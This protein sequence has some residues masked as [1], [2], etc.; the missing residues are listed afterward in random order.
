MTA[1]SA[2][3]GGART[4]TIV[5][6]ASSD[7]EVHARHDGPVN[8]IVQSLG[9]AATQRDVGDGTLPCLSSGSEL[10]LDSSES[11]DN[12]FSGPQDPPMTSTIVPHPLKPKTL[13]AM[14]LTVL[15]TRSCG[16]RRYRHSGYHDHCHPH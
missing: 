4:H 12:L 10:G 16:S 7:G 11:I 14:K 5:V 13:T 9:H 15:A 2:E 1:S 8:G 3:A 6:I